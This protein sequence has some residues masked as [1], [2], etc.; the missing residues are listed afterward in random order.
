MGRLRFGTGGVR[1]VMDD[2]LDQLYRRAIE[3]VAPGVLRRIE[4]ATA[5]V[6]ASARAAWPVKTGRSRDGLEHHVTVSPDQTSVRGSITNPVKYAR[7]IKAK[8]LDGKSAFVEL[9]RKPLRARAADL[10]EVLAMEAVTGLK[11]A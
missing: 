3:R 1:V 2:T 9:L 11:A 10:A 7:Y 8:K 6:Y 4:D 5:D